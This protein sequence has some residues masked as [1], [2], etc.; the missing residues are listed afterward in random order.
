M[1][2]WMEYPKVDKR[3]D[4]HDTLQTLIYPTETSNTETSRFR[5][6]KNPSSDFDRI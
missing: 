4:T 3:L 6:G 1:L 2:Q 5:L